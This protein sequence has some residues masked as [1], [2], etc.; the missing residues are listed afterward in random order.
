MK[1]SVKLEELVLKDIPATLKE[2]MEQRAKQLH[3]ASAGE[4]LQG[5]SRMDINDNA[6]YRAALAL[7]ASERR[8]TVKLEITMEPEAWVFTQNLAS[9]RGM[10][11]D[12]VI[13]GLIDFDRLWDEAQSPERELTQ[14]QNPGKE[15]AS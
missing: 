2:K 14:W 11:V 6:S 8:A 1:K 15:S 5:L 3:F 13:S 9:R 12:A 7:V 4:Y 10:T